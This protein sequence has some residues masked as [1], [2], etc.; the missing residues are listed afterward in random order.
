MPW[1]CRCMA[2]P[3]ALLRRAT[4]ACSAVFG[5]TVP[6]RLSDP[7]PEALRQFAVTS[8]K[9]SGDADDERLRFRAEGYTA[10]AETKV[11]RLFVWARA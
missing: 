6:N 7:K 4:C 2:T 8:R 3:E 11:E 10:W 1:R 9:R 5:G